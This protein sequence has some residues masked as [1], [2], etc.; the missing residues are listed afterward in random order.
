MENIINMKLS[1]IDKKILKR[2]SEEEV[3]QYVNFFK[4]Y[5][6]LKVL[7]I[8]NNDIIDYRDLEK[9]EDTQGVFKILYPKELNR[10]GEKCYSISLDLNLTSYVNGPK[11]LNINTYDTVQMGCTFSTPSYICYYLGLCWN[12]ERF[13]DGLLAQGL[14]DNTYLK[15]L[16]HFQDYLKLYHYLKHYD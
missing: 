2:F 10:L 11:K 7:N 15:L 9:R 6:E 14:Y 3:E 16:L 13:V 5:Q 4:N 1:I 12:G 8:N